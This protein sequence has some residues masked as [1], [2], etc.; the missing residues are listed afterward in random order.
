MKP[1]ILCAHD[2]TESSDPALRVALDYARR[3]EAELTVLFVAAPPYPAPPGLWFAVEEANFEG[4]VERIA[5]AA[6]VELEK[7]V[8]TLRRPVDA[9]VHLTVENGEPGETILAVA[10]KLGATLLVMGTH[11]RKGWQHLMLGSVAERVVRT[12]SLP[13][14]TVGPGAVLPESAREAKTSEVRA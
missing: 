11:A 9:P 3:L 14:L 4:L 12:A 5:A 8:K 13:V 1:V 2:L 10:K 6:R 7:R